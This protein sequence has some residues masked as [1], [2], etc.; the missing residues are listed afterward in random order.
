MIKALVKLNRE[1][2][3]TECYMLTNYGPVATM[4]R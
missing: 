4:I 2:H 3:N 1:N